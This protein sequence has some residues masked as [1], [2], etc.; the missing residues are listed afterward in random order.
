LESKKGN[1]NF[2]IIIIIFAV[3]I[4]ILYLF[5]VPAPVE[6]NVEEEI[7]QEI[8]E[9]DQ[10]IEAE[11]IEEIVVNPD[12]PVIEPELPEV[13]EE[14]IEEEIGMRLNEDCAFGKELR[15]TPENPMTYTCHL[16]TLENGGQFD[17]VRLSINNGAFE[18]PEIQ[19]KKGTT[20]TWVMRDR[21]AGAGGDVPYHQVAEV[22]GIF[23]S[24]ELF[25]S[26]DNKFSYVF[27]EVGEF[28]YFCPPHPWMEGTIIVVE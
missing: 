2:P 20:V 15:S 11:E 10:A 3:A 12:I 18:Q 16:I 28:K 6:L 14:I 17:D 25:V 5:N 24:G 8:E 19:V 13:V 21:T 7:V 26:G 23:D 4:G 1:F 9:K 27:D 22:N